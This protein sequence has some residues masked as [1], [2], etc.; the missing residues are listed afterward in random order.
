MSN[1]G[2]HGQ[3][4]TQQ[5]LEWARRAGIVGQI[6]GTELLEAAQPGAVRVFRHFFK[7][8]DLDADPAWV[9]GQIIGA[10]VGAK[11]TRMAPQL[12][13]KSCMV[14]LPALGGIILLLAR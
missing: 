11:F 12:L 9:A 6:D 4:V 3:L 7:P 1:L 10:Y 14:L 13:L 8:Q 5:G 2:P